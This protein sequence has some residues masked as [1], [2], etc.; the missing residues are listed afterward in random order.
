MQYGGFEIRFFDAVERCLRGG[1]FV[2]LAVIIL[3][4]FRAPSEADFATSVLV[5]FW[6]A[7]REWF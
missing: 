7:G 2:S 3:C 1:I 6:V 4:W 5:L